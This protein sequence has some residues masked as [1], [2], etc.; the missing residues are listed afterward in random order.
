M[1]TTVAVLTLRKK[2]IRKTV[3]T[4]LI[5]TD[6]EGLFAFYP[7]VHGTGNLLQG[8]YNSLEHAAEQLRMV[9]YRWHKTIC[10]SPEFQGLMGDIPRTRQIQDDSGKWVNYIPIPHAYRASSHRTRKKLNRR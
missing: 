5:E 8:H 9:G 1:Q 10:G 2:K 7:D 6:D 3:P 4:T